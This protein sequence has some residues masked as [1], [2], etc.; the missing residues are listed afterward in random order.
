MPLPSSLPPQPDLFSY[1]PSYALAWQY[2]KRNLLRELLAYRPDILCLQE[3]QS[4]HFAGEAHRQPAA[5]AASFRR[6]FTAIVSCV[7]VAY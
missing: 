7:A 4:D 1:C 3:V 2:R 5:L 6:F